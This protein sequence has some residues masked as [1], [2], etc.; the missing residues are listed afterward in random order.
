LKAVC[1]DCRQHPC[2]C[3]EH[4]FVT[5]DHCLTCSHYWRVSHTVEECKDA[6]GLAFC[7]KHG[8]HEGF[9]C[10]WQCVNHEMHDETQCDRQCPNPTQHDPKPAAVAPTVP[11]TSKKSPNLQA[12]S[13]IVVTNVDMMETYKENYVD[14]C[15][16]DDCN[17][18]IKWKQ[19]QK[20]LVNA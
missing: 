3:V 16:C 18:Y 13:G 9:V 12:M 7:S 17:K 11:G 19:S 15:S 4:G 20:E 1:E 14:G 6:N 8:L 10:D 2:I 5:A